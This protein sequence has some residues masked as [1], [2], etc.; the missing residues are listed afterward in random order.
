MRRA[1]V[2]MARDVGTT[3]DSRSVVT[4]RPRSS[5]A[6]VCAVKQFAGGAAVRRLHASDWSL[7]REVRLRALGAAAECTRNNARTSSSRTDKLRRLSCFGPKA[8]PS[9]IR[10]STPWR[11]ASTKGGRNG[12]SRSALSHRPWRTPRSGA[13]TCSIHTNASVETT[14]ACGTRVASSRATVDLPTRHG[15]PMKKSTFRSRGDR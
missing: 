11:M 3:E 7:L 13:P 10:L 2:Q 9:T 6:R 14:E 12:H 1:S 5:S 15:P 8:S 4:L